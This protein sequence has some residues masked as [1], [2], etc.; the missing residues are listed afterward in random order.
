MRPMSGES[1]VRRVAW[2]GAASAA[3]GGVLAAGV[4]GLL[5]ASLVGRHA[6]RILHDDAIEL[7]AEIEDEL[8]EDDDDEA[9]RSLDAAMAHELEDVDHP[10][11][12]AAIF[13][14]S[15]QRLIGDESLPLLEPDS[16][17]A[18]DVFARPRRVCAVA[19]GRDTLVL[20][21]SAQDER[22]RLG[23]IVLALLAGGLVGA[24][25]GG[26]AS[27]RSAS[28]ALAP[29]TDL[30]DRV[31]QIDADSPTADRLAPTS[32]HVEIEEL[33]IAIASLVER[34]AVSLRHA[35]QFASQAAHE[36][37]TPLAVLA[38]ELE[39]LGESSDVDRPT[40]ERLHRRVREL[41]SLV[42][43]LLMLAG[44]G[45][46]APEHAEAI[47]LADVIAAVREGLP[48]ELA[49]RVIGSSD[50]DVVVR[51]DAELI[52]AMLA[53]AVDNALKF[54]TE[55][56]EV[57]AGTH[58][59]EAWLEVIDFGPGVPAEDR[60]RV[61]A[62]FFRS[63]VVRA[64]GTPGHGIGMALIRHVANVHGGRCEFVEVARGARLRIRLPRW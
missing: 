5:A 15:G 11:A 2:V 36:L 7:A 27:R 4:A 54:S 39:L 57:R 6:D 29:L 58:E 42:Q 10:G 44:S 50:D 35:Q 61:F 9:P 45:K 49:E 16:C 34:L 38:G 52:R 62:P 18:I 25:L 31:R 51:G 1:L 59:A 19:F 55:R 56:V 22:E 43:R 26:L 37:R 64:E 33:R 14:A 60:D 53:N 24:A 17:R 12:S 30:R 13:S 48:A 47:D 40:L 20:G 41:V 21:V 3:L 32:D 46:L 63:A 23:L 8:D 28:W